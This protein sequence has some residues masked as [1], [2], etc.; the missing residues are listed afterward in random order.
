MSNVLA[1]RFASNTPV[2]VSAE[3]ADWLGQALPMISAGIVS[4]EA[5]MGTETIEYMAYDDYWPAPDNWLSYFRP[6]KVV[7]GTLMI[8]VKGMLL[9]DFPY[10]YGSWATGYAYLIKAFERGMEDPDVD[11]IALLVDSPGG[12]VAGC[13]DS[14]DVVYAMRGQKPIQAFVNEAAYSAAFAWA[15]VADRVTMTRTAGVGSVG[16]VTAHTDVS[17]AMEKYGYKITFIHAGKHKVDGNAYEALPPEVK[18]RIQA[19]I[20][21]M[22][23]IFV[24]TTAR[25]LGI[26]ESVVRGTEAL[27][28]GADEAVAIGFAHEIRSFD[29]AMAAFSGEL[30]NPA[31]DDEMPK[32]NDQ[33]QAT[34]SQADL[35]TAR[36]EGHADGLKVGATAERGRIQGIL[37]SE[38]AQSRRDMASHLAL[39][40]QLSVEEANG[41]LAVSPEQKTE[42][43]APAA[44]AAPGADFA[45][46]MAKDNP[47]LGSGDGGEQLTSAQEEEQAFL[48]ATGYGSNA[49]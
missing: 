44:T 13:F 37:A 27:T 45:A 49:K 5:K 31:G 3:K 2:L 1:A 9:H 17:A 12:E 11:R 35:D 47:N 36:A 19:R 10:Q 38:P 46:A 21:S 29:E 43:A 23:N 26:E 20:D 28:Y 32:P 42:A 40:T 24:S 14:A 22:Y 8:P 34:F 6:Y 4:L 33:E 16:V 25:N 7:S 30:D 18:A 48:A 39:N 15:T 41:I